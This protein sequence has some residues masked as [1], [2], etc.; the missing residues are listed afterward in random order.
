LIDSGN[1]QKLERFGV[2]RLVRFEPQAVWKHALDEEVWQAADATFRIDKG[3]S[4]GT[5]QFNH[6]IPEAWKISYHKLNF[7]I[8]ITNSRHTGVFPEQ[9]KNWDW[10]EE[11]LKV[12]GKDTHILNL[13]GYTGIASLFAARA[14]ARITH[15]DA[16][17]AAVKWAQYNQEISALSDRSIRWMVDDV[18]KFV[19]RESRRGS[20]YDGIILDPPRFGRGPKGEIWKF[21]KAVPELLQ[22][23]K[24]ILSSDPL[25]IYLTAYDI[26]QSPQE[27]CTWLADITR[28]LNGK[29]E[30]G[31]LVQ[32]EK[33]AGRKINQAM[34]ARWSKIK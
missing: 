10:I 4:A 1:M 3:K 22:A 12:K 7:Q 30:Y 16:S 34:F 31:K 32:Q 13:F 14:G 11:K 6:E 26:S 18:F 29:L 19:E 25:F 9:C 17:R 33:S 15:V 23:C 24:K 28:G 5:W 27:L 2:F 20:K 21:E 8:R